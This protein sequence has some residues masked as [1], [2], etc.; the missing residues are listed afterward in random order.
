MGVSQTLL[1]L[2]STAQEDVLGL[3][4]NIRNLL[5]TT[6]IGCALALPG[7]ASALAQDG[8]QRAEASPLSRVTALRAEK[9]KE[10]SGDRVFGGT[11]AASGAWPFQVALL[12]TQYLDENPASQL[13]SQFCGGSLIAPEWVLTAAHCLVDYGQPIDPGVVTILTGATALDEGQRHEVAE[14]IVHPDYNESTLDADIGL[15]RLAAPADAPIIAMAEATPESGPATVIGWGLME[16]GS[17][18]VSLMQADIEM[19][20]NAACNAGIKQLYARDL[21]II[22]GQFATRMRYSGE[23]VQAATDAIVATMGDPL[24]DNMICAGLDDGARDACN[25]DS[26]GPLF[27]TVEGEPVQ[28]GVVSWGEGPLDGGAACGH[29]NAYGIYTRLTNYRDWIATYLGN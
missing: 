25:G 3:S 2:E 16:N 24:T 11:E 21:G 4:P 22:L 26:G 6:A 23:G 29:A 7:A 9:A 17:F 1:V 19:Q 8:A 12:A 14:V 15:I 27:T 10:D 28:V 5:A 13:N 18:P 20:S